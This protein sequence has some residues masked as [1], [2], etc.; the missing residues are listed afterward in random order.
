[1]NIILTYLKN[2]FYT[3]EFKEFKLRDF[4]LLGLIYFVIMIPIGGVLFFLSKALGLEHQAVYLRFYEKIIFGIILAPL[5]EELLFRLIF[6]FSKKN[7]IILISIIIILALYFLYKG[8]VEKVVI[9]T[10]LAIIFFTCR[11]FFSQC[12]IYFVK[13]FKYF[14][15]LLTSLFAIL[16]IFNF[17]GV[18]ISNLFFSPLIVVPQF[19]LGLILGYI[20]VN[21]GFVYAFLFHSMVN[22]TILL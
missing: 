11:I 4:L 18:S 10:F 16:H 8:K 2:P 22:L 13:Y 19:F 5:V 3:E 15:Y 6:L 7:L 17:L 20:R 9:F 1:M 21:N 12:K 14:F